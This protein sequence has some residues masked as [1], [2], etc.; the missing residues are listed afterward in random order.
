MYIFL[1]PTWVP[2][3]GHSLNV[4]IMFLINLYYLTLFS[5]SVV[6]RKAMKL[7]TMSF[8]HHDDVS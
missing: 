5:V 2:D 6:Y 1:I 3:M 4:C 7:Y 8:L